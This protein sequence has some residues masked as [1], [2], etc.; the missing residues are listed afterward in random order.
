M[1]CDSDTSSGLKFFLHVIHISLRV[2][3]AASFATDAADDH[4]S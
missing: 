3:K 1:G 4:V 2:F